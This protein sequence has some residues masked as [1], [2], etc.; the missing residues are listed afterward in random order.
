[1]YVWRSSLV[2]ML[3]RI[4]N[5]C[6]DGKK[7]IK[8]QEF[9]NFR[10]RGLWLC[11]GDACAAALILLED[12]KEADAS[13]AEILEF[14]QVD[15]NCLCLGYHIAM[16]EGFKLRAGIAVQHPRKMY[17]EA[18]ITNFVG[19]FQLRLH[20]LIMLAHMHKVKALLLRAVRGATHSNNLCGEVR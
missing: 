7:G 11:Q 19:Y 10:Y 9:E 13:T 14:A 12:N 3:D 1:M 20:K 4:F 18:V 2:L 17:Q 6:M 8:S 16:D 15:D 5:S